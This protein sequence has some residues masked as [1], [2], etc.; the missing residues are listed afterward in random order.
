MSYEE[1]IASLEYISEV[2]KQLPEELNKMTQQLND[3]RQNL[4]VVIADNQSQQTEVV[5]VL[6]EVQNQLKQFPKTVTEQQT[7]LQKQMGIVINKM[8]Q[9]NQT[10]VT[11]KEELS[12]L[13][14]AV[15]NY[16]DAFAQQLD[17][18][19]TNHLQL[20]A[21]GVNTFNKL[22]QNLETTN[23]AIASA[24]ATTEDEID[25]LETK[26]DACQNLV[27][28]QLEEIKSDLAE[29]DTNINDK[30]EHIFIENLQEFDNNF[31][32]KIDE[33]LANI[34]EE[35]NNFTTENEEKMDDVTEVIND[36]L[37]EF[38][39]NLTDGIDL[40]EHC[41]YLEKFHKTFNDNS[42]TV[43]NLIPK[44]EELIEE[45]KEAGESLNV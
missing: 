26:I 2:K 4:A 21:Q 13:T 19:K 16:F 10:T 14:T 17:E 28:N 34:K 41:D 40:E 45:V 44:L 23:E 31:K 29:A 6:V 38:L 5:N 24:W 39:D 37:E 3:I 9:L 20:L 36:K 30:I 32:Q 33:V 22:W 27:D 25:N 7:L 8:K 35:I 12:P 43:E 1:M 42:E 18:M 11:Q 15:N